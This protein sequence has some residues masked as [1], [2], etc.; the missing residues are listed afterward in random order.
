MI[1]KRGTIIFFASIDILRE[2]MTLRDLFLLDYGE[3]AL[4]NPQLPHVA[5]NYWKAVPPEG[6]HR[7]EEVCC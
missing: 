7:I 2:T 4:T 5:F 1:L 6:I 3:I